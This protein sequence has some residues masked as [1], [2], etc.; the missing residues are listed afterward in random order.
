MF[1]DHPLLAL[2]FDSDVA[3]GSQAP[4]FILFG[5]SPCNPAPARLRYPNL[6]A[7]NTFQGSLGNGN[8]HAS[9]ALPRD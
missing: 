1:Y 4:Q 9:R 7:T 5:G 3:D 8:C 2:A 6:N